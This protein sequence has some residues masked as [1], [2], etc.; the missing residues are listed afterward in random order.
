MKPLTLPS[1]Q[2]QIMRFYF[3]QIIPRRGDPCKMQRKG[4]P[5]VFWEDP[6]VVGR[7]HFSTGS[8][9]QGLVSFW[10]IPPQISHLP[11]PFQVS[12]SAV[13]WRK[14]SKTPQTLAGDIAQ[15]FRIT[16]FHPRNTSIKRYPTTSS[17]L[18]SFGP[19]KDT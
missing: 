18:P 12:E 13:W 15:Q 8:H 9:S 1:P 7:C 3:G 11:K 17:A 10:L 4:C 16:P 19:H 6:S 2:R 14:L 5:T